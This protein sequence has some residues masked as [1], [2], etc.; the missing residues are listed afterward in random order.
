MEVIKLNMSEKIKAIRVRNGMTQKELSEKSGVA[1]ITIRKL[2]KSDNNPKLDTLWKIAHA[3]N[4]SI[5]D[6]LDLS[7][8]PYTVDEVGESLFKEADTDLKNRKIENIVAALEKIGYKLDVIAFQNYVLF[9]EKDKK[10]S[11][12]ITDEQLLALEKE[13][14][15]YLKY[16]FE[17]LLKEFKSTGE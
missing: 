10:H 14:D 6:I 7:N 13:S 12:Q 2:E 15:S 11:K 17:E 8:S 16:K 4:V 3:L 9:V 1:E 5:L